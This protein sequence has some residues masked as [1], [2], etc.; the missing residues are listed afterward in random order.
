MEP[1]AT[2]ADRLFWREWSGGTTHPG[3]PPAGDRPA[4]PRSTGTL[5]VEYN[6]PQESNMPHVEA[7]YE[8]GVFRPLQ[9]VQLPE[10]QRVTVTEQASDPADSV[11]FVLSAERWQS[12]CE[13]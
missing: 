1:G 12:F 3:H 13:A 5:V 8:N 10:H 2:R 9:P 6:V 4:T 7:I 11:H